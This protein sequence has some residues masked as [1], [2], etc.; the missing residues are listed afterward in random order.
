MVTDSRHIGVRIDRPVG[1][2]YQFAADPSNLPTWA[3]GLGSSVEYVDNQWI[4][5]SP[6]GRVA[7]AFAPRNDYG[8]LDH[9][10]TLPN[11]ETVCNPMRVIADG[12]GCEVVFTLRRQEGATDEEFERDASAVSGDLATLKGVLES[13]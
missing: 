5:E 11:G 7:V 13:R 3:P 12:A 2:T 4:A 9:D 8:I 10:V 6:M 1:E